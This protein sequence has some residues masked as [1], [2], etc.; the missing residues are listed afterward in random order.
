[1]ALNV[2]WVRYGRPAAH[3][4]RQAISGAKA[5]D[6]LTPVSVV[7][8]SNQVGVAARRLLASGELGPICERGSGLAA[9]SFLTVYRL[10]ELLGAAPLAA[11][12]R[13]PVSTPVLAAGLRGVLAADPGVFAPV[14]ERLGVRAGRAS[15]AVA[16]SRGGFGVGAD[17]RST[18]PR[19]ARRRYPSSGSSTSA[20]GPIKN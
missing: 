1:M 11:E 10:A 3:L 7:V 6:P 4:L 17:K 12:D 8:P 13:R 5:G 20:H 14:A 18:R 19:K 2:E 15:R 9:V 16:R